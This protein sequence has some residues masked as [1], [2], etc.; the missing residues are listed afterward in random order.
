L[1]ERLQR[2][3]EAVK[4][5]GCDWTILINF[6]SICYA[7]GRAAPSA[8]LAYFT[9]DVMAQIIYDLYKRRRVSNA[10]EIG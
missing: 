2:T 7:L 1:D 3:T 10:K 6:D 9:R 4:S 8:T 5:I